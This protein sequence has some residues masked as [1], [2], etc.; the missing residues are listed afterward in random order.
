MHVSML[1]QQKEAT[2]KR[3]VQIRTLNVETGKIDNAPT[4]DIQ[5]IVKEAR[6]ETEYEI[7]T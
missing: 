3:T 7:K 1:K 2:E 6:N 5:D 4:S